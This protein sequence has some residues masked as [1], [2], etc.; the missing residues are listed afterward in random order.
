MAA[1]EDQVI[2]VVKRAGARTDTRL[3]PS[4]RWVRVYFGGTVVADSKRVLV[5]FAP[6]HLP[7]YYFPPEDVRTDLLKASGRTRDSGEAGPAKL[8]DLTVG[9]RTSQD[10]AWSFSQPPN[11]IAAVE[12]RFAFYWD[13]VDRWFEEDDEVYAHA[14][15]PYH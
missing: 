6:K 11:E 9:D 3:E 7:V 10:V 13:R 5:M 15:D 4:P 12:G 14:R 1:L 2:E 8:Y